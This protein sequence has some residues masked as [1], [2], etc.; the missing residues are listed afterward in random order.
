MSRGVG[1]RRVYVGG[2][3]ACSEGQL[4]VGRLL[5]HKVFCTLFDAVT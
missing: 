2:C 1:G 3:I 5:K 4:G